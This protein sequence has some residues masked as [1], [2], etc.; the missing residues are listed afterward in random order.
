MSSKRWSGTVDGVLF[1]FDNAP[2]AVVHLEILLRGFQTGSLALLADSIELATVV[3]YAFGVVVLGRRGRRWPWS[4][5]LAFTGGLLVVFVAVGSGLAAY[6]ATNFTLH[7]V[8]HVMLMMGAPPLIAL[9]RPVTLTL[10]A[11]NRRTQVRV[12]RIARSRVLE[13][14]TSPPVAW[15]LYYGSMYGFFLTGVYVYSDAHPLFH[16]FT[17]FEFLVAGLIY[18]VPVIGL[19][20]LRRRI[21]YGPRLLMLGLGMPFEAF[22]GISIM[23]MRRPIDPINTLAGTHSGGEVLWILSG[24]F[25]MMAMMVIVRLWFGQLDRATV[26]EDRRVAYRAETDRA[27]ARALLGSDLPEGW[28][29]PWWRVAE[30]EHQVATAKAAGNDGFAGASPARD[31]PTSSEADSDR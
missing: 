29:L 26:Q 25:T 28:T 13:V 4:R 2:G 12:L 27:T 1:A 17:H 5:T 19:D 14:L 23:S 18:W 3:A 24:V 8:Q 21:S 20:P 15:A 9:G 10:Q 11:T 6:D 7:V 30:L 31:S 16:D 22:L